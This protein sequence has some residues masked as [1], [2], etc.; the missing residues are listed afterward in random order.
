MSTDD[1]VYENGQGFTKAD[2]LE[3]DGEEKTVETKPISTF[4]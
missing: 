1:F 2:V 3:K 4:K